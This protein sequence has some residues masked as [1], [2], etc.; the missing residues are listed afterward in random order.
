MSVSVRRYDHGRDFDAVG[1]F[2]VE[3][4]RETGPRI[5]WL[6]PRWEYMH[7]HPLIKRVDVSSIGIWEDGGKIVGAAH[8]EHSSGHA[9]FEIAPGHEGLKEEILVYAEEN[10][11]DTSGGKPTLKVYINDQD[12]EFQRIAA[13]RGYAPGDSWEDMS[14]FDIPDPFPVIE[15]A[16]GYRL[17]T[18]ADENDLRKVDQVMWR[19]FNHEG[20]LPDNSLEERR[21]MQSAPNFRK[22][23]NVV[24]AALDG[25]YVSYCGMWY[26]PVHR[27][28]YVEPVCTDPDYR[29]MG[30]GRAAVLEGIRRCGLLGATVAYVGT[31]M[32]FYLSFGFEW[33]YR[34]LQWE[35][36]WKS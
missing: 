18:L 16:Q 1:R 8:P 9:Y 35:K 23:L 36:R 17:Q 4:Y 14:R 28:A 19:G 22:E 27:M 26:E 5:N 13:A 24:V 20:E 3:T 2:L 29:R 6:Q 10:L 21:F 7:Y 31:A 11:V 30:L 12:E 25:H 32:P 33:I 34:T 15:L